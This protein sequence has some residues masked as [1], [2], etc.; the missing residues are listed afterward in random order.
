MDIEPENPIYRQIEGFIRTAC[1][2]EWNNPITKIVK[3]KRYYLAIPEKHFCTYC[4]DVHEEECVSFKI[5]SK[6]MKQHCKE[7]DYEAKV[8]PTSALLRKKLFPNESIKLGKAK[9]CSNKNYTLH[10]M[11]MCKTN[12]RAY[13]K[14]IE[15][16]LKDLKQFKY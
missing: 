10:P 15:A 7:C 6:G 13:T 3:Y 16:F 12:K 5:S 8:V 11:S 4:Q 2:R 9:K 1:E 14:N